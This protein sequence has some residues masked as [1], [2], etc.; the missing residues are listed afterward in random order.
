MQDPKPRAIP[1]NQRAREAV[2]NLVGF[3]QKRGFSTAPEAPLLTKRDHT[4]VSTRLIQRLFQ[5]LR[6]KAGLAVPASPHSTRHHFATRICETSGV[7]HAMRL[8]GHSRLT[9]LQQYVTP[10]RD[11]LA[12]AVAA[13]E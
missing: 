13:L 9:S 12:A 1:L 3:L 7:V 11:D 8:M 10:T 5:D 6:E 2:S 4:A